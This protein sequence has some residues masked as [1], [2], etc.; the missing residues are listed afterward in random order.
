MARPR[1]K[2][3]E[4]PRARDDAHAVPAERER[5][6]RGRCA[7]RAQSRERPSFGGLVGVFGRERH[8]R[9]T[10]SKS[11]QRRSGVN[12][13]NRQV[14]G[15]LIAKDGRGG[16][17]AREETAL[18]THEKKRRAFPPRFR[19]FQCAPPTPH[20]RARAPALQS[21]AAQFL[22]P[23]DV[24]CGAPHRDCAQ[25]AD[26]RGVWLA[27]AAVGAD[28]AGA[29]RPRRHGA[30]AAGEEWPPGAS[31]GMLGSARGCVRGTLVGS[32]GGAPRAPVHSQS[33]RVSPSLFSCALPPRP[34]PSSRP[35]PPARPPRR[36]TP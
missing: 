1:Q 3:K 16:N 8:D 15:A 17:A 23:R 14:K 32:G 7:S 22:P 31:Q 28:G 29:P 36:R 6:H 2:Q 12:N 11:Q 20:V 27:A 5:T 19:I 34:P 18:H 30:R 35:R 21:L 24:C 13:R 33:S 10:G 26:W 4:P 25:R 9:K